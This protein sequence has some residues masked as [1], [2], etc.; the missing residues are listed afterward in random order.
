MV[1][2][3]MLDPRQRKNL[4]CNFRAPNIE[5]YKKW[6][7]FKEWCKDNGLDICNVTLNIT[8]AFMKGSENFALPDKAIQVNMKNEFYYQVIK[9][10]RVPMTVNCV[11]KQF[12]HTVSSCLYEA[13][14]LEKARRIKMEFSYRDFLELKYDAFRRIIVRLKRKGL[15]VPN[16]MR[17]R[18]QFYFLAENLDKKK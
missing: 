17:T 2:Q 10:R 7:I 14:I 16:P 11:K 13:Y 15:V 18:P 3:K 5:K 1:K 8:E 6:Q 9:P 12:V 4:I